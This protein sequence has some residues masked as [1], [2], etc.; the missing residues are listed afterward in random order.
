MIG[1]VVSPIAEEE[2]PKV[3]QKSYGDGESSLY[4]AAIGD[5]ISMTTFPPSCNSMSSYLVKPSAG[6]I[7]RLA[8]GLIKGRGG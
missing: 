8:T 7:L 6:V 1:V 4:G 2:A 3:V 5:L